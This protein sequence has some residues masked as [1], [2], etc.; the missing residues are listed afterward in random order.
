VNAIKVKNLT[1]EFFISSQSITVLKNITFEIKQGSLATLKGPSGSGKS[2]LLSIL[3][4]LDL[5]TGGEIEVLG[6]NL[7]KL[8][9]DA[10][11][12]FRAKNIGFV[13]QSFRLMPTLT[14]LENVQIPLELLKDP[15]SEKK[16]KIYLERVGL[17][18]RS[19]HFPSQ[20]SG[21][22]QQRVALA[23]AFVTQP[24]IL[25]A[26]EP[27]GN[28]DSKN[29]EIVLELLEELRLQNNSTLFVVTHDSAIAA[30]GN[31]QLQIYDGTVT[32]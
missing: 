26:D 4:G 32:K 30:K 20:L 15:Q 7:T 12:Q 25:F 18:P 22:E 27:T 31:P 8:G 14:A 10:R 1:K 21:G 5:P 9:E 17:S 3:A 28:L 23:R 13:F 29:G 2:T 24:S 16:A 19:H 11:T 6:E